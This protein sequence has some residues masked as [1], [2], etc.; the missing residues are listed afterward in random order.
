[1]TKTSPVR[2]AKKALLGTILGDSNLFTWDSTKNARLTLVQG[3]RQID[4]LLWKM[5]ILYPLVGDFHVK[6]LPSKKLGNI[7]IHA[8][9]GLKKNLKHEYNDFY[10]PNGE[11]GKTKKIVRLNVLRRLTP[12]S[13]AIWYMD[14]GCLLY[15]GNRIKGLRLGT[16][17]FSKNENELICQYLKETWNIESVVDTRFQNLDIYYY[18]RLRKDATMKFLELVK[19]FMHPILDYKVTPRRISAE[20]VP[21]REEIVCSLQKCGE[22]VRNNQSNTSF[23]FD[24]SNLV[25]GQLAEKAMRLRSIV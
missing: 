10:I 9:T 15:D 2:I 20:H 3:A 23:K 1:M 21:T 13:L 18:I 11:L 25:K 14:D 22:L 12:L 4:Y 6:F 24:Y 8:V 17:G 16:Y 7:V 19:D 5:S